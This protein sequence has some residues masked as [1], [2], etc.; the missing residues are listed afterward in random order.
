MYYTFIAE[1]IKLTQ[2][3]IP[4]K[5]HHFINNLNTD[6]RLQRC[7]TQNIDGLEVR[8]GLDNDLNTKPT[9][10]KTKS[11]KKTYP[12]LVQLHG[13]LDHI[14]CALCHSISP[15]EKTHVEVY[16]EG[17]HVPCTMCVEKS[18][19][20]VA[21]GRRPLGSG[22]MKPHIVLYNE[23]HPY[24]DCIGEIMT[25][26]LRKKPDSL[27]IMGTTLKVTGIK[28]L[29][30]DFARS[31][32]DKGGKV[33]LVNKTDVGKEWDELIDYHIVG[34]ADDWV[35]FI[36]L[37]WARVAVIEKSKA[38]TKAKKGMIGVSKSFGEILTVTAAAIV[39]TP[40]KDLRTMLPSAEMSPAVP[41]VQ[42]VVRNPYSVKPTPTILL[43]PVAPISSKSASVI[44]TP[45]RKSSKTDQEK[46]EDSDNAI[47]NHNS[48]A[49]YSLRP[50]EIDENIEPNIA[51]SPVTETPSKKYN[52]KE[53]H[54]VTPIK[55]R[56]SGTLNSVQT[57]MNS[58]LKSKRK[59]LTRSTV[60][61]WI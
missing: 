51:P 26:D 47:N 15:M 40:N 19:A 7:Y 5:T 22:V 37:E 43:S 44:N 12:P 17:E 18:Q 35:K 55:A 34:G 31:V 28:K 56:S 10:A 60:A 39:E 59:P 2:K 9:K 38:T 41:V 1:L 32:R 30:R 48:V 4:T 25:A 14:K 13:T 16:L 57:Q 33:I 50:A 52:L 61:K 45:I 36:E 20:R 23:A 58:I 24:G 11:Q 42:K 6:G 3:A 53:L 27:I 46:R 21:A 29:V 49:S 8:L 54:D